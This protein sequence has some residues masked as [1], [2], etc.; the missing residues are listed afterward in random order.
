MN[1]IF[2]FWYISVFLLYQ[3]KPPLF[4]VYICH[5]WNKYEWKINICFFCSIN[6][7]YGTN[8]ASNV[9]LNKIFFFLAF[10]SNQTISFSLV[11]FFFYICLS[12]SFI[13][14][15]FSI[16]W[17][18]LSTWQHPHEMK[19]VTDVK[20]CQNITCISHLSHQPRPPFPPLLIQSEIIIS[21]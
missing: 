14:F 9:L 19:C 15:I 4:L 21:F 6:V 10:I 5:P 7:C 16:P 13:M 11:F 20:Q 1:F 18:R 8:E 12:F 17:G 3:Q 2:S